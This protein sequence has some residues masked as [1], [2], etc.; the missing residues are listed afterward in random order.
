MDPFRS[1]HR[2]GS[3][4]VIAALSEHEGFARCNLIELT[5]SWERQNHVY[6]HFKSV[7]GAHRSKSLNVQKDKKEKPKRSFFSVLKSIL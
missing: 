7:T 2:K 6:V 1:R 4:I 5:D 3:E